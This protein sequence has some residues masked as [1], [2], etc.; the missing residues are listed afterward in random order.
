[1]KSNF[2]SHTKPQRSQKNEKKYIHCYFRLTHKIALVVEVWK[3]PNSLFWATIKKFQI[4]LWKV[5]NVHQVY[6]VH[7]F[8][9]FCHNLL[10]H[11]SVCLLRPWNRVKQKSLQARTL[12]ILLSLAAQ[13]LMAPRALRWSRWQCVCYR[14]HIFYWFSDHSGRIDGSFN[15]GGSDIFLSRLNADGSALIY[16]TYIGGSDWDSAYAV[17]VIVLA[18]LL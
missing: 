18:M 10:Q 13:H 17:A 7:N 6:I 4:K 9:F 12:Y 5:L 11:N 14:E 1:V 16:S 2:I 8:I 15:G 3:F